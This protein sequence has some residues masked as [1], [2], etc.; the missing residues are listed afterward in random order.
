MK[1]ILW[2]RKRGVRWETQKRCS[3]LVLSVLDLAA[4]IL[5]TMAGCA[6][7]A[8][9]KRALTPA[10]S[11]QA[12][13]RLID[14][15]A[16]ADMKFI[17]SELEQGP[18]ELIPYLA[19]LLRDKVLHRA[20]AEHQAAP[21]SKEL[22][23]K[24]PSKCSKLKNIP[25][26]IKVSFIKG[27]CKEVL[28][29]HASEREPLKKD[30]LDHLLE[31]ALGL[32]LNA[33]LPS[34]QPCQHAGPLLQVL[35]GRAA[36]VGKRLSTMTRQKYMNKQWG[37]VKDHSEDWS[38]LTLFTGEE[39]TGVIPDRASF[40]KDI[41]LE[42]NHSLKV[43]LVCHEHGY[44]QSLLPAM[45]KVMVDQAWLDG[46]SGLHQHYSEK[47]EE[48]QPNPMGKEQKGLQACQLETPVKGKQ[49]TSSGSSSTQALGPRPAKVA[50]P[51]GAEA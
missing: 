26:S 37:Y 49:S 3:H 31:F 23:K 39:L 17:I 19:T 42:D 27:E 38:K 28:E 35:Q 41:R 47:K 18:Q 14:N 44:Q 32:D 7:K 4:P 15:Q 22:G 24:L 51:P 30:E 8:S 2:E 16:S 10:E 34:G 1:E 33:A 29:W 20:V 21:L 48:K 6:A 9:K 12:F 46:A 40:V 11:A 25:L 36:A 45:K 13:G 50:K 5:S 43:A